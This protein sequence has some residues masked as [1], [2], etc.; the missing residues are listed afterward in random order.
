MLNSLIILAALSCIGFG[1][2]TV[3]YLNEF[4]NTSKII[5]LPL[6]TMAKLDVKK[7]TYLLLTLTTLS[8]AIG[9][10]LLKLN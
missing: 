5:P 2:L 8:I 7:H 10:Y 6:Y 1:I 3:K 4:K 9:L